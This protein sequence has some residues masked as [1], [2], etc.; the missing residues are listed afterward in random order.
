MVMVEKLSPKTSVLLIIDMQND[1]IHEKGYFP[2]VGYPVEPFRR[3]IPNIK[4]L[5]EFAYSIGMKVIWTATNYNPDGSDN[6]ARVHKILAELFID[7][8][9]GKPRGVILAK[10]SWGSQ[11]I[12]ELKPPQDGI[13]ILKRKPSAFYNT[14]LELILRIHGI[15][16]L[17]ITGITTEVC[18][19][20]TARDAFCRDFDIIIVE[21]ATATWNEARHY[22]T[23]NNARFFLGLVAKTNQVIELFKK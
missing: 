14:N 3:I 23:L 21:D 11:I 19:D 4:K 1:F 16:T 5:V 7:R 9:N 20:T 10:G 17:I 2:S 18:V 12:D 22:C 6:P 15:K 13:V 8:K